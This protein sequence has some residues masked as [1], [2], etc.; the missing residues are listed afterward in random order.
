MRPPAV[1]DERDKTSPDFMVICKAFEAIRPF[2][3]A[4]SLVSTPD[5]SSVKFL[6]R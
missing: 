2:E 3:V 1:V 4:H 6:R 5:F